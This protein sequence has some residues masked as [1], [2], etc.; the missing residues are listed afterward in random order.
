MIKR[1]V[2][3]IC[4][5]TFSTAASADSPAR[6]GAGLAFGEPG[7]ITFYYRASEKAFVQAF[8][9]SGLVLG[10]D[11]NFA[12]TEALTANKNIVPY[13][14]FG[15]FIFSGYHWSRSRDSTGFGLRMPLG[16]LIAIPDAPFHVHVEVAP[17]TTINP[18]M[19]SFAA[20]MA[21]VRFLF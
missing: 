2:I 12:F 8:L 9:G 19:Y 7:G 4:L 11:Y 15:G 13:L 18:F 14:G 3:V 21:G 20:A 6:Y 17:A 1:L 10:G 16:L 5:I